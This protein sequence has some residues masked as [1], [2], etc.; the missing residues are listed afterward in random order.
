MRWQPP[1][2]EDLSGRTLRYVRISVTDRCQFRCPYCRP[3]H[4]ETP[5]EPK[6]DYLRPDEIGRVARVLSTLGIRTVRFTGGEPLLRRDLA[7]IIAAVR[8]TGIDDLALTTNAALL[9]SERAKA[10]YDAGLRRI[11]ISL[12]T[13]DEERFQK[14]SGGAPMAPVL[15][16]IQAAK[17][18]GMKLKTNTVVVRGQNDGELLD[19]ARYIWAQGGIPRFI[20]VMPMGAGANLEMV[21]AAEIMQAFDLSPQTPTTALRGGIGPADYWLHQG[22][23]DQPLGIIAATTR[24]FCASCNRI[25]LT[26]T[27]EV[28]PCLASATGCELRPLLRDPTLGDQAIID[29]ITQAL[30]IK[31]E[32]HRFSEGIPGESP[33]RSLGG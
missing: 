30:A 6:E 27:G 14:L 22:R 8:N 3:D 32:G 2:L 31:P 33:M 24:N 1:S 23:S 18:T 26:S 12:D 13:L 10:L 19:I 7:Q 17:S 25:R 5:C 20:E 11:N 28:R 15:A 29:A 9:N 4:G 21:P 16:G